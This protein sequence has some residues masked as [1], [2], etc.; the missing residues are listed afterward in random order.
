MRCWPDHGDRGAVG[1]GGYSSYLICFFSRALSTHIWPGPELET[2]LFPAWHLQPVNLSTSGA[3]WKTL[4]PSDILLLTIFIVLFLEAVC[5]ASVGSREEGKKAH[6]C[7]NTRWVRQES[8]A[9]DA[10]AW[11]KDSFYLSCDLPIGYHQYAPHLWAPYIPLFPL[12]ATS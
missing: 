8:R 11:L 7:M 5:E 2:P 9:A 6:R 1:T 10:Y 4:T 12:P 3:R